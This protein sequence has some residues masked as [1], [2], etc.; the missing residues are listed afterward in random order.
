MDLFVNRNEKDIRN[1]FEN[2]EIVFAPL[3]PLLLSSPFVHHLHL[4][5]C[6]QEM[7]ASARRESL[8]SQI[9]STVEAIDDEQRQT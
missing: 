9:S 4:S 7:S 3:L 8:V 1:Q 5:S 6:P 2:W